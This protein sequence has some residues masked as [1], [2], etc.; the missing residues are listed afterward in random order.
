M[1]VCLFEDSGV[2]TFEPL[3]LTRPVFDLVCGLTSLASKQSRF[4]PVGPRGALIRAEVA[5]VYAWGAPDVA[6]NDPAW[7]R[8]GPTLLVNGRWLPPPG[9]LDLDLLDTPFV[10]LVEDEIA[11][12]LL[13]PDDLEVC[14]TAGLDACLSRCAATLPRRAA[15]GQLL[16]YLWQLV[17]HNGEQITLDW[18]A[19]R[20]PSAAAPVAVV[21]PPQRLFVHPSA[22]IDPYV[23]ADTRGGPVVIEQ[24]T[25][26]TAF[27]RLEGPCAIG[28]ATHVQGARI[29]CGTTIGPQCR[30]GGE[31]EASIIQGHSNKYHDGF[32]GHAYVGE[33]V[34]LGAGTS[35]SDLRNDY[36]P[37]RVMVDGQLIDTGLTK[38]GCFLGDHSKT[39]LGVL[40]N[41]GTSAGV[42]CSL[43]PGGLLPRHLPSFSQCVGDSSLCCGELPP[44]LQTAATVMSR[45]GVSLTEA[46]T[47]LYRRLYEQTAAA[48]HS[49]ERQGLRRSA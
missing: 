40:L 22:H 20:E 13:G 24:E 41:T 48:W 35:N 4:F 34:N 27:S 38:V 10:A 16:R 21:G 9:P 12:A 28:A 30:I 44:L 43:L 8:A 6:V 33:W 5:E 19:G 29:R 11:Y 31:I 14:A 46:H 18:H 45:R 26:I 47:R 17:Q 25:I 15:G 37:V 7:L 49:S 2:A 1:R 32:L 3:S 36:G 23:V 39:G 42:F